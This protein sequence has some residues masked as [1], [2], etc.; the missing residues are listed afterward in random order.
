M[1][2]LTHRLVLALCLLLFNSQAQNYFNNR[3]DGSGSCD[4][5]N[6]IDTLQN[7][8]LTVG[9]ECNSISLYSLNL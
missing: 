2:K 5:T 1:K 4:G 8:Y 9:G 6:S 3:Y 7:K